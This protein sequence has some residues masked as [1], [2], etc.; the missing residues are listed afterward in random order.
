MLCLDAYKICSEVQ[1]AMKIE[2]P[3]PHLFQPL[4]VRG[5]K[6]RNRIISSPHNA[7]PNTVRAGADGYENYTENAIA[8]YGSIARG[9]AAVVNTGHLGVDPEYSLGSDRE[10]FDFGFTPESTS[11]P[12]L[13][14]L[15]DTI[16]AY[17]ALA[18]LE[19]NH[20]GYQLTIPRTRDYMIAPC[21]G[22]NE[23]GVYKAMDEAEMDRVAECFANAALFGK[24][25]GFDIINV[26]GAHDWLIQSFL[27]PISNQRTDQ[28]GGNWENRA[29]FPKMVL[30]RIRDKVG[31]NTIIE[32]RFN[33]CDYVKGG[34][35]IEDAAATID[36]LSDV[37]DIIQCTGGSMDDPYA[38]VFSI[39]LGPMG[40]AI[41][42]W[43][44]AEMKK[45]IKSNVIIETVG[46]INEPAL[47]E[48]VLAE[49]KADLV[50]MARSFIADPDWARKAKANHAE[51]I[52]PC[53]RCRRCLT[54]STPEFCNRSR[55]TVNPARTLPVKLP[56]SDIPFEKKTVGVIGGGAAGM[57]CA[58]ELAKKGHDVIL[59]E[60]K[61]KLGGV[62]EFTD[63]SD[64][65]DD[66]KRYRDYLICQVKK[67]AHI[68]LRLNTTATPELLDSLGV[69]TVVLAAGGS[70]F[71]PPVPGADRPNVFH[72]VD[73][74]GKE[75]QLGDH[76]V[77]VGGG[78]VGCELTI[79]LQSMGKHV[80]VVE[81]APR[82]MPGEVEW[83][84]EYAYIK[85]FMT[86]EFSRTAPLYRDNP[87]I[88]RVKV[89]LETGCKEIGPDGVVI[90]GKDGQ[91]VKIDADSVV[92]ATG[93]RPQAALAEGYEALG[94]DVYVVGDCNRVG[95]VMSATESAYS[96]ALQI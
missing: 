16:H 51:D 48:Q 61:D 93:F 47:A 28:Y 39:S 37:V 92:M 87:E 96:A 12:T 94:M 60:A 69:D 42:A 76:V 79:H 20:P 4:V 65:K 36:Y 67:D 5:K 86:H 58:T 44:A 2:K 74:Y 59:F 89:H 1:I 35:S 13:V 27:S 26:H 68:D 19:L 73:A 40:H 85:Y 55:C 63:Y 25:C 14:A 33:A 24:R 9:G 10:R 6:F 18:S 38:D 21:D 15:T 77:V 3:Y 90:Q 41:N 82:L 23:F 95:N 11:T 54:T 50:A 22:E 34:I 45:R 53:I 81:M 75:D 70:P 52:R 84:S 49:G 29:R 43:S 91:P 66:L 57:F 62:L 8:Y 30:Q 31:E 72:A 88:D 46:G 64:M 83:L 80:D 71:I 32:M 56:A 7:A 17:G 78:F